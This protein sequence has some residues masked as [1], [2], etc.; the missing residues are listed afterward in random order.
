MTVRM[1]DAR[2][3]LDP[4]R[5][6]ESRSSVSTAQDLGT[7]GMRKCRSFTDPA[8]DFTLNS[9]SS[10][11]LAELLTRLDI[12]L[13]GPSRREPGPRVDV[14]R[15]FSGLPPLFSATPGHGWESKTRMGWLRGCVASGATTNRSRADARMRQPVGRCAA[16]VKML[17]R[18]R[19]SVLHIISR[20]QGMRRGHDRL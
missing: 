20:R 9:D 13:Q 10:T 6:R 5:R 11:P 8:L 4:S 19:A 16:G 1:T 7:T 18:Y 2:S 15:P 3:Q 17:L 14:P 12:G